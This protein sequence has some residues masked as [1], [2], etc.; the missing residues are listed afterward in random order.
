M[1]V[2]RFNFDG[3]DR[4]LTSRDLDEMTDPT[5]DAGAAV[6]AA[7]APLMQDLIDNDD[8]VPAAAHTAA[9]DP[10]VQYLKEVDANATYETITAARAGT[11]R[12]PTPLH[13]INTAAEGSNPRP[14][15]TIGNYLYGVVGTALSRSNDDGATWS[16]VCTLPY[17]IVRLLSC[18]DGEVLAVSDGYIHKSSGWDT[19]P[20]TATWSLKVD[21]NATAA[22]YPF[23]VDGDGTKFIASQ[24][25][26]T[27]ADSRYVHISVD[28]GDTWTEVWDTAAEYP[29]SH[30]ESH[31]H[32]CCYDPWE[33]RFWF[34]EGHGGP[35][36]FYYSDDD[37][38]NWTRLTGGYADSLT[39]A[40]P[41]VLVATDDGIVMGTDA[42]PN[43]IMGI[44]RAAAADLSVELV[45]QW[46]QPRASSYGFAYRGVRDPD[47]GLVYMG[48]QSEYAEVE[49]II[50]A[51]TATTG[52]QVWRIGAAGTYYI[53]N[54]VITPSGKLAAYYDDGGG[55]KHLY[56]NLGIPGVPGLDNPGNT[57]GA[58][59]SGGTMMAVG[60]GATASGVESV[61]LG[62]GASAGSSYS[63]A[64][65]KDANATG[66]GGGTAVG[67]QSAAAGQN[68]T[69]VGYLSSAAG[70]DANAFGKSASASGS[71]GIAI[72]AS[73]A[74]ASTG[75][76]AIG[77]NASA[78][79]GG[80][81][82]VG[83]AAATAGAQATAIGNGASAASTN[84]TSVG[85]QASSTNAS[86]VALGS[87][88]SATQSGAMALGAAAVCA[89]V[90]SIA[91]GRGQTATAT[92]QLRIGGVH[93]EMV[94]MT[95]PGAP[96]ADGARLYAV[97]N[98]AGKT[99][100]MVRFGSGAAQQI[101]IE[102]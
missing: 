98:G 12:R 51:G 30:T 52:G 85:Y 6:T 63:T 11:A 19:N 102:P 31:L 94:E 87:Q 64:V 44:R 81:T 96:A 33:D 40:T 83:N 15:D 13:A 60:L 92:K 66:G 74:A 100:L 86:N 5:S 88:A 89:H 69:A 90:D 27:R 7:M 20:A 50:A 56:A 36:G 26:A 82:A 42:L 39:D 1:T 25:A 18:D 91:L 80:G 4:L 24:Y 23:S 65:G 70:V 35:I 46:Q 76:V 45:W 43:G 55:V 97:D 28:E 17:T 22:F 9:P 21:A 37:G 68:G 61:A 101:A 54:V 16:A 8:L 57:Q 53:R 62:V 48:W 10:H 73:A 71:Y 99:Q 41:T 93:I 95:A 29:A 2:P 58:S 38:A 49:A 79:T 78:G 34:T 3:R 67:K 77:R 14:V 75:A 32:G 72:G 84:S 59:V 47:T